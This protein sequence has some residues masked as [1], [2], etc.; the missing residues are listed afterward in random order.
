[1][2]VI[3]EQL[4]R[5]L[6]AGQRFAGGAGSGGAAVHGELRGV[7]G[8]PG[9]LGLLCLLALH[10]APVLDELGGLLAGAVVPRLLPRRGRGRVVLSQGAL[11]AVGDLVGGLPG[12]DLA[13]HD[14]AGRAAPFSRS[15]GAGSS[16]ARSCAVLVLTSCI[17]SCGC[18][19]GR[20]LRP[21]CGPLGLDASG[22]GCGEGGHLLRGGLGVPAVLALGA[23]DVLQGRGDPVRDQP[24]RVARNR[25]PAVR[26]CSVGGGA[27][28]RGSGTSG[29]GPAL[30]VP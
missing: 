26:P 28:R 14:Q 10:V 24:S 18:A 6:A 23:G 17:P 19:G 2:L 13:Q 29:A 16:G 4:A 22:D 21:L 3:G 15:V 27:G 12:L 11:P 5:R 1:M 9:G 20:G 30:G 7:A 8:V 25:S